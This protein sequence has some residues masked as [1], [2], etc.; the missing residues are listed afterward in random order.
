MSL[1]NFYPEKAFISSIT[2]AQQA[3]V[4]FDA[5]HDYTEGEIISFR[6]QP[7]FG[8]FEINNKKGR[9]LSKTS[10]TVT[11][12][13]DSTTWT[14]FTLARLNQPGTSPPMAVPSCSGVVPDSYLTI[15]ETN[16]R[17]AFDNRLN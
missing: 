5:D 12:D 8:M 14:P 2:N 3:V 10:D 9:V 16:V 15:P 4:T 6:V 1:S 11:V 7:A 13:I 17:D